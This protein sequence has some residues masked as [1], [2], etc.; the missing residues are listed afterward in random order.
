MKARVLIVDDHELV[1]AGLR[2][3]LAGTGEFDVVAEATSG[4]AAYRIVCEQQIDLV[5]LDLSLP[6]MSGI[7]TLKRLRAR[8]PALR[9]LVMSIHQSPQIVRHAL[10]V[11]ADGYV[12]KSTG[13]ETMLAA[14]RAVRAGQR[15]IEPDLAAKVVL[16]THRPANPADRL[17]ARELEILRL[18]SEGHT[19]QE[20]AQLLHVS[21]KTV[22]NN[23]SFIRQKLGVQTAAGLVQAATHIGLTVG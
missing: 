6:G 17:S 5:T 19:P 20:I 10:Q 7:E 21:T 14:L 3:L 22:F 16:A 12:T 11:G 1:R 13:G 8:A 4:E 2:Q 23:L 9:C 15:Y 18:Y